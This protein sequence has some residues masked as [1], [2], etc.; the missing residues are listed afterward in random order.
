MKIMICLPLRNCAI[1]D[2]SQ[3]VSNCSEMAAINCDSID[4]AS[5]S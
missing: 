5:K 1:A 3:L 4:R 2:Y